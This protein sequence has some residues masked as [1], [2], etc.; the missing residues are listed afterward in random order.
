MKTLWVQ[1]AFF[2]F[3]FMAGCTEKPVIQPTITPAPTHTV[4]FTSTPTRTATALPSPTVKEPLTLVFYGDSTLKVGEVGRQ[5]QVGFSFVDNL[6]TLLDPGYSLITAN[7]GGKSARWAYE[8][9]EQAV[10]S[11]DPDV[12]TIEWGWDDLHGCSGIFDRDTNSLVEYKLV[13]LIKDHIKYLK[14]QIDALLDHNITVFVVT[15]LPI[16][17]GLPWSY[18]GPNNEIITESN[19]WCNYNIG[20]E[21]LVD[22]QKQLVMVYTAEQ[23][24]VYLVDAWQI[25][26]NHPNEEKMYMDIPHPGSHGA[27]LIAE[28]W[29]QV[30]KDSLIH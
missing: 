6:R 25:Y 24:P 30:F 21:Q 11:L 9:L 5:G 26:K 28:G 23:K 19:Y 15:P 16:N 10:L 14:L 29:V 1:S 8:N 7:Y 27:Q 13:A 18:Y 22:A 4:T 12:V 20:I 17:S 2:F 3:L